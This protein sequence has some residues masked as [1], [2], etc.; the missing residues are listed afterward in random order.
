MPRIRR[1]T[2]KIVSFD[3]KRKLPSAL[4]F[5]RHRPKPPFEIGPVNER[6]T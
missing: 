3:P 5:D 4:R 6:E 2:E 1:W